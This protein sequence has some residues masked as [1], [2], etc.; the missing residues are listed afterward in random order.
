MRSAQGVSSTVEGRK[1]G[2]L[3]MGEEKTEMGLEAELDDGLPGSGFTSLS[4]AGEGGAE[5]WKA[6]GGQRNQT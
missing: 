4:V 6:P 5:P 3:A 1:R 2:S